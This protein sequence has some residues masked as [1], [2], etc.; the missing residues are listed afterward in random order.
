M[1]AVDDGATGFRLAATTLLA[2]DRAGRLETLML[3]RPASASFAQAW[4]WP[5]GVVDAAD[6]P[7]ERHIDEAEELAARAAAVRELR[8]ETGLRTE[9][10]ELVPY[11]LW[12]PP[13]ET[14]PRFRTWFFTGD[15]HDG[16]LVPEPLEVEELEWVAPADM[17]DAHRRGEATLVVPTWVTLHQLA[18]ID[19]AAELLERA[20]AGPFEHYE[21]RMRDE[22]RW[23]CWFGDAAFDDAGAAGGARHRLETA[24]LPWRYSRFDRAEEPGITARS[25]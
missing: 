23:F 1:T 18:A 21:T 3:R 8:E 24:S 6:H 19:S 7:R 10:D 15:R 20:A 5:G 12:S 25:A 14:R 13:R 4:V 9:A 22:G 16:V 17:L 11:A 2:R